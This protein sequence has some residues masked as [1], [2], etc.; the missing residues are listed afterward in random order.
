MKSTVVFQVQFLSYDQDVEA[1]V[2]NV[3]AEDERISKLEDAVKKDSTLLEK[4]LFY[5]MSV[6]GD[7]DTN[8]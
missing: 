3:F 1:F 5:S 6:D 2:V 8:L 7:F 4:D